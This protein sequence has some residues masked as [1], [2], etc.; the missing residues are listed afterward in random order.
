MPPGAAEPGIGLGRITVGVALQSDAEGAVAELKLLKA[1][2]GDVQLAFEQGTVRWP[3][4]RRARLDLDVV[5]RFDPQSPLALL[6]GASGGELRL[7]CAGTL[8]RPRCRP[9]R[10]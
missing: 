8:D 2:G 5:V 7:T 9:G 10:R 3:A 1:E 4:G 6:P